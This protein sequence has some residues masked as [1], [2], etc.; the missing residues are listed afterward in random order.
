MSATIDIE[1]EE[2]TAFDLACGECFDAI[3]QGEVECHRDT[4][5]DV[6]PRDR[7]TLQINPF[8]VLFGCGGGGEGARNG[9]DEVVQLVRVRP[10]V[11]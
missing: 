3:G 5:F 7:V 10:S 9:L 6:F 4:V 8:E 11:N 1:R 2:A